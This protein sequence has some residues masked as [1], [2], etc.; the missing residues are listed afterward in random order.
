MVHLGVEHAFG[1]RLLQRIEQPALIQR[2][3]SI[4][5]PQKLIE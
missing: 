4:A 2:R 5:A 1:Q 3:G